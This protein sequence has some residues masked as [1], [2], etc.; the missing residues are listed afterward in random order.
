MLHRSWLVVAWFPEELSA[1]V[2]EFVTA[3][4]R[5]LAWEE[6]AEDEEL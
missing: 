2:S 1:P 6:L 4:L 5:G 3:A